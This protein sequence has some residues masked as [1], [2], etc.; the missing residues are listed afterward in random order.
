[1]RCH[2]SRMLGLLLTAATILFFDVQHMPASTLHQNC[3][4]K[5]LSHLDNE[6]AS[7][8]CHDPAFSDCVESTTVGDAFPAHRGGTL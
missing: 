3:I 4:L 7:A 1:M 2:F 6:A 5:E 8:D